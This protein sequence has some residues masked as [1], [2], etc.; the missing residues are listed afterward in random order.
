MR[1]RW[2]G[3]SVEVER[4]VAVEGAVAAV[5]VLRA[6][7]TRPASPGGRD[8]GPGPGPGPVP[9]LVPGAAAAAR[10]G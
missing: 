4:A 8:P 6:Q 2:L 3:G 5:S 7:L 10:R 1:G 9:G